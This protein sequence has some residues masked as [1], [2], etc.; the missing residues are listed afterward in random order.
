MSSHNKN[1]AILIFLDLGT[2]DLKGWVLRLIVSTSIYL[3]VNP[4]FIVLNSWILVNCVH[5]SDSPDYQFLVCF[6]FLAMKN[7][8]AVNMDE[9][10][11][12]WIYHSHI[13]PGEVILDL[14]FVFLYCNFCPCFTNVFVLNIVLNW[15]GGRKIIKLCELGGRE[16]WEKLKEGDE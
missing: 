3:P 2:S 1:H 8:A 15:E 11:S 6:Q 4:N 5:V 7:R 9:Q 14:V 12:L 10:V 16:I 13:S